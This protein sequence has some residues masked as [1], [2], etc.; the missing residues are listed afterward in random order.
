MIICKLIF[1]LFRFAKN[2]IASRN[3]GVKKGLY[4][5]ICQGASQIVTFFAYTLTFW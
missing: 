4:L 2:L 5:G 1:F 3:I